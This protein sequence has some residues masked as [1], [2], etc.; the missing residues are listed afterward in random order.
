MTGKE[1]G[2]DPVRHDKRR[3]DRYNRTE[4]NTNTNKIAKTGKE[5]GKDPVIDTVEGGGTR[6]TQTRSE[7]HEKREKERKREREK[8]LVIDMVEGGGRRRRTQTRSEWHVQRERER[9]KYPVGHNKETDWSIW[10]NGRSSSSKS[11]S[12]Y[13]HTIPILW[14]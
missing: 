10:S 8:D 14:M 5:R 7:W 9:V 13:A 1:R 3:V 11:N 2:K 4:K 12:A 6:R